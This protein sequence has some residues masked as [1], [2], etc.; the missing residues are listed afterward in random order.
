MNYEPLEGSRIP[1]QDSEAVYVG[2]TP[3]VRPSIIIAGSQA[4]DNVEE[5]FHAGS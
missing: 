4:V 3:Y 5:R 1:P 2:P